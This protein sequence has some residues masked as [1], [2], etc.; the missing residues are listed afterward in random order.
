MAGKDEISNTVLGGASDYMCDIFAKIRQWYY[1]EDDQ[2]AFYFSAHAC[3]H[4]MKI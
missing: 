1:A 3:T 4:T 2:K